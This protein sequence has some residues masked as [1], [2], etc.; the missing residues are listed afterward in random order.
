MDT[1]EDHSMPKNFKYRKVCEK[2]KPLHASDDPFCIRHPKMD[3]AKRA[4]LFA[5]FDALRGFSAAVIAKDERYES[6]REI[7]AE[8]VD[9]L[10]QKLRLLSRLAGT[11]KLALRNRVQVSITYFEP[12]EDVN[13]E[14]Y[15]TVGK[16][17]TIT[18]TCM[19]IDP[20]VSQTIL[21]DERLISFSDIIDI[22]IPG[23][24]IE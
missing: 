5:P 11:K 12:C 18:G 23:Y 13:N 9:K 14:F 3:L 19:D 8:I 1:L 7:D 2:G 4:K 22:D 21:L 10:D 15:G 17:R 24:T 6:R 16:Y 20:D